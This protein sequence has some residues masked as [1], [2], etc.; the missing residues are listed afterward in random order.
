MGNDNDSEFLKLKME[1]EI[2]MASSKLSDRIAKDCGYRK[3]DKD[4]GVGKSLARDLYDADV[5]SKETKDAIFDGVDR[6]ND[7]EHPYGKQKTDAN[8]N[9][10]KKDAKTFS[11]AVKEI[12]KKVSADIDITF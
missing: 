4:K 8:S 10:S 1:K 11:N 2:R 5:I 12:E 9:L 3:N 6:R 7:L